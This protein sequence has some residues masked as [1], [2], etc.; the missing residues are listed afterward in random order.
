MV[1]RSL[2]VFHSQAVRIMAAWAEHG[3]TGGKSER[4]GSRAV[5]EEELSEFPGSSC[6]VRSKV[7]SKKTWYLACGNL[8]KAWKESH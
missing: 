7:E 4:N 3:G 1:K 5:L 8:G 6:V 2:R